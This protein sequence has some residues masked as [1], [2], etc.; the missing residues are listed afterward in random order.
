MSEAAA[1]VRV[2]VDGPVASLVLS[3][4]AS[5]NAMD[6]AMGEGVAAAVARINALD[7]VRC[8]LVRGDGPVF[9]AGGARALLA[10]RLQKRPEDNERYM[11]RFYGLFLS[12][13][14]LRAPSIAVVQGAAMGAG[15]C[16]ALACDVRVSTSSA[17]LG[18]T[19]VQLGLHPGMGATWLLP[20]LVGPAVAAE[21]LLTGRIIDG[22]QALRLGL[23]SQLLP[24]AEVLAGSRRLADEIARAAPLAVRQLTR[25][26]RESAGAADGLAA[27][28]ETE[29]RAQAHDY[30]SADAAEGVR[31]LE[32]KRAPV[33]LGR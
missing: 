33:F 27:A 3:R 12:V 31:A 23:V 29:A 9:C 10:S 24:D 25:T 26:L 8:V 22:A 18:L 11:R 15:V 17:R 32:E 20:R 14:E 2:E 4:P 30:L 13:R 16:F 7:D 19:F 5:R 6:D 21:L 28:L 1:P